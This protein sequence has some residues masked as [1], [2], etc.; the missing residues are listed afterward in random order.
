MANETTTSKIPLYKSPLVLLLL[1]TVAMLVVYYFLV[2]PLLDRN[3]AIQKAEVL[4][5]SGASRIDAALQ[6]QTLRVAA[7]GLDAAVSHALVERNPE[8]I[9]QRAEYWQSMLPDAERVA[10]LPFDDL[11]HAGLGEFGKQIRNNI[12]RDVISRA[13][14]EDKSI[15]DIYSETGRHLTVFASPARNQAGKVVGVVFLEL[16]PSWLANL[17]NGAWEALDVEERQQQDS[18]IRLVSTT[19]SSRKQL[20]ESSN[21]LLAG[22]PTQASVGLKALNSISIEAANKPSSVSSKL[23][24]ILLVAMGATLAAIGVF[25]SRQREKRLRSTLL[26]DTEKLSKFINNSLR[27]KISTPKF[28]MSEFTD[29]AAMLNQSIAKFRVDQKA[30]NSLAEQFPGSAID[31][32]DDSK[33]SEQGVK[34]DEQTSSSDGAIAIPRHIFRAYDVRGLA[35]QE[36]TDEI[37]LRIGKAFG[38]QLV[39]AGQTIVALGQD[40]RLSSPRLAEQVS[41]GLSETGCAVIELGLVPTP[42]LYFA[43][44]QQANGNG[45]MVTGSHNEAEVNGFK[46]IHNGEALA[47]DQIG[48]LYQRAASG[49][50]ASGSG[51][52]TSYDCIDDYM[53]AC[54]EDVVFAS[55]TKVVLDCCNGA[56]SEI[57]PMLYAALGAEV[58]PLFADPDGSFPNHSPNP[59]QDNLTALIEE[60]KNQQADLG[61]AFDGDADRV[62]AVTA[63]GEVVR[64]DRLLMLFAKDV[65]TRNPGADIV[66][67]VKCS[68]SL[69]SLIAGFGGR[70]VLWKSGHSRI[71]H[72]MRETG[73]LLGGEFSGHFIFKERWFGFDDGLYAGARLVELLTLEGKTLEEALQGLPSMIGTDE[74]LLPIDEENK[75]AVIEKLASEAQFGSADINLLDGLRVEYGDGWGLLRAS[76]TGPN[77]TARF[78]ADDQEALHRI[79]AEF[80]SALQT[81]DPQLQLKL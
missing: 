50:F 52:T 40:P 47:D 69:N 63:S 79:A 37:A 78:E 67:D 11:G 9:A 30:H 20:A 59:S 26:R 15:V 53:D 72:K 43:A 27:E 3:I 25:L 16:K 44:Q 54:S 61:L 4:A 32:V 48:S 31:I 29:L 77:L 10:L 42:L 64:S 68:R 60:V 46:F 5:A 74:I 19:F 65:L 58:I 45:I 56:A 7:I 36:L 62:V 33:A 66:F 12:E 24:G 28:E 17:V 34:D 80:A 38:S 73:A 18:V 1:P 49:D 14:K 2:V 22:L 55:P 39:E 75:Y 76:N 8:T 35:D 81:I 70:P 13:L 51:G 6:G 21:G 41:K 71:K 57:A 23:M